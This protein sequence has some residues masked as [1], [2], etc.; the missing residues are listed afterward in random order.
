MPV[1]SDT[2]SLPGIDTLY[3][4][5]Q[6]FYARQMQMLDAGETAT[7]AR[8]FTM[9]GVFEAG[10][11]PEPVKGREA[12]EKAATA[13]AREFDRQ[14]VTRRHLI[15]MLTVDPAGDGTVRAR[16]YAVVLE[17]PPGGEV[18]VHRS[19]LC[20]DILVPADGGWLVRQRQVT[21]DGLDR[22]PQ[23]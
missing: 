3:G 23:A 13:T 11:V 14:G 8:T 1:A 18:N 16:S 15:S 10:G 9:D 6:H 20:D 21:R 22:R 4:Q 17:I 7:W 19:T 12:I 2:A 5:V